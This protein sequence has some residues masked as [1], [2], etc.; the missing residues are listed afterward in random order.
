MFSRHSTFLL[1]LFN[2]ADDFG[3]SSSA[4]VQNNNDTSTLL[5]IN[6]ISNE[7]GID[8]EENL[9]GDNSTEE[10][11]HNQTK[12]E[13]EKSYEEML[14]DLQK[15]EDAPKEENLNKEE[16][17]EINEKEF[18]TLNEDGE[19]KILSKEEASDY[20]LKG[21]K[22]DEAMKT[23][24]KE[25]EDYQL[26]AK[27]CEKDLE[28]K[29]KILN[30]QTSQLQEKIQEYDAWDYTMKNIQEKNPELFE[31]LQEMH[32]ETTKVLDNPMTRSLRNQI[33]E[34][35]GEISSF[36]EFKQQQASNAELDAIKTQYDTEF[37]SLKDTIIPGLNK[38]G[39]KIDE[40]K[41]RDAYIKGEGSKLTAQQA[42]F[43]VYG[44]VIQKAYDSKLKRASVEGRQNRG[45]RGISSINART[46]N[47]GN[48]SINK[49]SWNEI[50]RNYESLLD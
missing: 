21:M 29:Y 5:D 35:K 6:E 30:D 31:Q 43:Q 25:K 14:D 46:G 1:G 7:Y 13:E 3:D 28:E 39:I 36:K 32:A 40:A 26:E 17:A 16:S 47:A 12:T 10:I 24:E 19:S 15:D 42:L 2:E 8:N 34:L 50:E 33:S 22:Y 11:E 18:L 37:N 20:A 48:T 45:T 27:A 44:P 38:I 4:P 23:F 9:D 49:M 41:V